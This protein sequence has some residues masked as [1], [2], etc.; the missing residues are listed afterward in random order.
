MNK[1]QRSTLVVALLLYAV[2]IVAL[3]VFESPMNGPA[4]GLV[5]L[6]FGAVVLAAYLR[7]GGNP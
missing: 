1:G 4:F 5:S 3:F 7:A 6:G 2:G